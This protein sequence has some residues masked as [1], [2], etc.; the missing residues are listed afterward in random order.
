MVASK[1]I[2]ESN[3]AIVTLGVKPDMPKTGYGY[4][5]YNSIKCIIENYELK[6]VDEFIEKPNINNAKKYLENGNFLW[7][8][9]M[10]LWKSATILKHMKTYL[11][12]TYEILEEIAITSEDMVNELLDRK[13]SIIDSI[14]IDY[15]IMEK[16]N[17]VFV[18]PSDFGWD[19][20][21][22]SIL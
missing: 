16:V 3:D 19:D 11:S 12:K 17:N 2:D 21:E 22:L 13:Y 6:Y 10:F 14:S 8:T 20:M 15:G 5:K 4:I 9:G 7:N 18:I 1:F